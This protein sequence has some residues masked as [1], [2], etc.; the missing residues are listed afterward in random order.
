[1]I[2]SLYFKKNVNPVVKVCKKGQKNAKDTHK[3]GIFTEL[4]LI[5]IKYK[6]TVMQ[7]IKWN[8]L[9]F[10]YTPTDVNVRCEYKDGKWGEVYTSTDA[11]INIHMAATGLHYGQ[12][13][14]EGRRRRKSAYFPYGGKF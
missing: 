10:G 11:Y 1:M 14:F 3:V 8:E 12:E 2:N 4:K 6:Q 7:E 9:S 5:I 13:A